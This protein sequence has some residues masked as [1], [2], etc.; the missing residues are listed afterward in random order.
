MHI[1]HTNNKYF[2]YYFLFY[3]GRVRRTTSRVCGECV[4]AVQSTQTLSFHSINNL[5][6]SNRKPG[7]CVVAMLDRAET[8]RENKVKR[9]GKR[10]KDPIK[11]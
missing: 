2:P 1:S 4:C 6:F 10:I 7:W 11:R 9:N 5:P 3:Y 8:Q